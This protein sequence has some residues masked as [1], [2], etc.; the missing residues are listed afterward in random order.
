MAEDTQELCSLIELCFGDADDDEGLAELKTQ[1]G[2]Y[3][4]RAVEFRRQLSKLLGRGDGEEC[5][6]I[7][8]EFA[9]QHMPIEQ[10]LEWFEW[11]ERQLSE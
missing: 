10:C 8:A 11:L 9:H 2:I 1:L 6:A 4:E 3:T 7:L 5:R